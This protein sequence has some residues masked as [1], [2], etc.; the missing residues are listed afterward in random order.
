MPTPFLLLPPSEGKAQGGVR[1]K[2]RN[3]FGRLLGEARAQVIDGLSHELRSRRG[4]TL[5]RLLNA[6]GGLLEQAKLA[7]IELCEGNALQLPAWQRF[8]GV[9]WDHLDPASLENTQL[10]RVLIPTG[11]YGLSRGTDSIAD[12]RLGMSL[13]LGSLGVLS[14]FWNPFVTRAI[15]TAAKGGLVVDLLPAEHGA[16]VDFESLAGSV[17][18]LRVRFLAADGGKA[19]GHGAKA[20]KG[21]LA[22]RLLE[23]GTE[24]LGS[25]RWEGWRASRL[26]ADLEV[27]APRTP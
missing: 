18:L 14:R 4:V 15:A 5:E 22:R 19:A 21:I 10:D 7:T 20:V 16:A 8:T 25:F 26:G 12:F 2:G 1:S 9:V 13:S 17:D 27:V 24:R 3:S 11:P 23:Q 6:R